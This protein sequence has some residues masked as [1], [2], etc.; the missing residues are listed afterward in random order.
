MGDRT[1]RPLTPWVRHLQDPSRT[2]TIQTCGK[3]IG[4][5]THHI[6]LLPTPNQTLLGLP[7]PVQ[8]RMMSLTT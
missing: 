1:I 4:R 8:E 3:A 5:R 2:T 7:R 6:G